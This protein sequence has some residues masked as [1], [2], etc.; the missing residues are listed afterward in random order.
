MPIDAPGPGRHAGGRGAGHPLDGRRPQLRPD[1]EVG[2]RLADD[3]VT[4]RAV[5]RATP[6]T[7][8]NVPPLRRVPDADAVRSNDSVAVAT[9][10]PCPTSPIRRS[11][12]MCT[13][14]RKTS[15]N[16]VPPLI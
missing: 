13:S 10:H 1:V 4:G 5:P 7:S 14:E 2:Q 6:R 8:A 12:G 3:G 15:L 11:S 9:C 16:E